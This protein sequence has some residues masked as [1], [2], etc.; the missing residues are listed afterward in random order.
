MK[1]QF[2]IIIILLYFLIPQNSTSQ[3]INTEKESSVV[4]S[5]KSIASLASILNTYKTNPDTT[6]IVSK[7]LLAANKP[8]NQKDTTVLVNK[9]K[10]EIEEPQKQLIVS[11]NTPTDTL[12][13]LSQIENDIAELKKKLANK[14]PVYKDNSLDNELLQKEIEALQKRSSAEEIQYLKA[15]NEYLLTSKR[16]DNQIR[17][18]EKEINLLKNTSTTNKPSKDFLVINTDRSS[19]DSKELKVMQSKLDSLLYVKNNQASNKRI[20]TVSINGYSQLQNNTLE[21]QGNTAFNINKK[22]EYERLKVKYESFNKQIFFANNS[23]T[24]KA[25]ANS[26]INDL[27]TILN[28]Y[29]TI[30]VFINGFASNTGAVSKNEKL[31]ME[32][33]EIVKKALV[34]KSIHPTRILTQ[35][36]GIDYKNTDLENARRVDI[37]LIIRK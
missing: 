36:H 17:N 9:L 34:N 37:T 23:I 16:N 24:L 25:E 5:E 12:T 13:N 3:G 31:S 7:N 32:R 28:T 21:I 14:Q 8:N 20:E 33:T 18:L 22:S 4:M 26:T 27:V 10:N 29:D 2:N 11:Q 30:D 35:Y 19:K 15:K 6:T 1:K